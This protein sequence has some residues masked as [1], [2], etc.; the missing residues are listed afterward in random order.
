MIFVSWLKTSQ[1]KELRILQFKHRKSPV[2]DLYVT[3]GVLK[4]AD[5]QKYNLLTIMHKF[6]YTP[7]EFP[8]ELKDLLIQHSE[9]M[10]TIQ[11]INMICMLHMSILR[12]MVTRNY[13]I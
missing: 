8:A 10:A 3:S 12:Y 7:D 5:M 11:E 4:L 9:F 13:P 1:N 2:D 6:M